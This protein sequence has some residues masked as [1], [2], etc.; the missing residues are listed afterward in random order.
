MY[1]FL[2]SNSNSKVPIKQSWILLVDLASCFFL[3]VFIKIAFVWKQATSLVQ[4]PPLDNSNIPLTLMSLHNAPTL[5]VGW[6]VSHQHKYRKSG[7]GSALPFRREP[8]LVRE[9]R[10]GWCE[11]TPQPVDELER[12]KW[13]DFCQPDEND[14]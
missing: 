3:V 8:L 11:L 13:K 12:N 9:P 4:N 10:A 14:S 2:P 1:N 5:L 6:P 7:G